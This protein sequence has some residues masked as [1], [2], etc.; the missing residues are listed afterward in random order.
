MS[1][2]RRVAFVSSS[3]VPG[4]LSV[5][6]PVV[7]H[8]CPKCS[9]NQERSS[10]NVSR[11]AFLRRSILAGTAAILGLSSAW[12]K[13]RTQSHAADASDPSY[14]TPAPGDDTG[15]CQNCGGAG[16]V[17][18]ELCAGTGF[19]RAISGNDPNMR[20]K[21]VVCPEC[22]GAGT[23]I[24]PVCLGTGEGNVRGLLRRRAVQPGPGRIL[25]S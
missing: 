13:R 11:R 9:A 12:D 15:T 18:C 24:C 17:P 3:A 22:E 4:T 2:D 21:G 25:Q 19:W 16:K 20:Y 1:Q 7:L 6:R 14:G 10:P 8:P 23:I 5:Q